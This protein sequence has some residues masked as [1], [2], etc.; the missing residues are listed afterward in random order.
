MRKFI[1]IVLIIGLILRVLLSATTYHSDVVPFDFAGKVIA[2]GSIT[3]FYDYLWDLPDDSPILKVYPRNLFNYPPL[4]YFFLG[5]VSLLTTW[6]VDPQIHDNFVFD[7]RSTLGNVNLNILLLL[8]KL[9]YFVFDIGIAFILMKLFREEKQKKLVFLLWMF[10]PVNLYATYMIGQFDIIPTFLSVLALYFAV[11]KKK[12]Y[13]ASVLLGLGAGFK[14]FPLLFIIPLA[15]VD[16]NLWNRIRIIALGVITYFVSAFPFILSAGF[17]RTAMLAGQT[18]KSFYAQIPISGGESVILFLAAITFFYIVS[19]YNKNKPENLW[20]RFFAV[21]LIFFVFTHFHPQWFLWTMPFFVIELAYSRMK[22][23]LLSVGLILVYLG[24]VS[25]YDPGL[26]IWLFSPISPILYGLPG[27][28]Q[29]LGL[30]IDI[31]IAR[32]LL[33]TTFVGISMY[34]IYRYFPNEKQI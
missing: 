10:N 1:A 2:G 5:G 22:H 34:Y 13:L 29:Q 12:L 18:T 7:F 24:M 33:H 16:D 31:N 17:R 23:W 26:S 4:P 6:M 28:W 15:L 20:Q 21:I 25:F 32:S 3:N 14:I 11:N 27:I 8:L 9:P 30:N 19:F